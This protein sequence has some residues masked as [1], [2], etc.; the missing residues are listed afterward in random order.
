MILHIGFDDTD[1]RMGGCTTY[2]AALLVERLLNVGAEFLEYP[3]L[4]R[5]NPNVPWKTRGNGALCLRIR[6]DQN[7][8]KSI[9]NEVQRTVKENMN[10]EHEGTDPGIVFFEGRV[11][12]HEIK[13]FSEKTIQTMVNLS[14]ARELLRRHNAWVIEYGSGLGV[15]GALAAI[16][17]T[18]DLDY[19]YELLTYRTARNR[20]TKR[21]LNL[22]SVELMDEKTAPQ[23]FGSIDPET[24]RVLITPRGGDPVLYGIRG[25]T[26]E[27]VTKAHSMIE[28]FEE[29]ERWVIFRTNQ[30]TDAHLR[31][32]VLINEVKPHDAVVVQGTVASPPRLV[33]KRHRFFS[34][35]DGTGEIDCAAYEP[36]GTLRKAARDLR[37]G[38]SVRVYGGVRPRS[39]SFPLTVN[40][41]KM[42]VLK[43]VPLITVENPDCPI[44]KRKRMKSRG[45]GQGFKCV[46]CGFQSQEIRKRLVEA[47]R[48]LKEQL[49][50]TSTRSRR[51]LTKP[52]SRYGIEKTGNPHKMISCWHHP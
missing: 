18:L 48:R 32:N 16:G 7:Q 4:I 15:I 13:L 29:I 33:P 12:P 47:P 30:G 25:E 35:R 45:F 2:I 3:N 11:I 50:I 40:L 9:F 36:T 19:T 10:L 42:E 49:Y 46:K 22:E 52:L 26:A 37:V 5:L 44:C 21:Q 34:I 1:S 14:E 51:H 38:D 8:R 43:L 20:G 41:E 31:R 24:G 17:E 27:V 23:T 6:C 28:V 39:N